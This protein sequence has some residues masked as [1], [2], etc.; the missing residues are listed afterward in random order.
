MVLPIEATAAD[1]PPAAGRLTGVRGG[2]SGQTIPTSFRRLTAA[3]IFV[4][5]GFCRN[6]RV[7][8]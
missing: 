1:P 4:R 6:A 3:L 5:F 2:V 7:I 8:I